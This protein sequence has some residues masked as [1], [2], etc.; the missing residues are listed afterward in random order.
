MARAL[1]VGGT[2]KF[3]LAPLCQ[4]TR[5]SQPKRTLLPRSFFGKIT[6]LCETTGLAE[7]R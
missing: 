5:G 1:G 2:K 6:N 3:S 7:I 4:R